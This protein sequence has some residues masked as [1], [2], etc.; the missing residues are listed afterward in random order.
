[1]RE[2]FAFPTI[3]VCRFGVIAGLPFPTSADLLLHATNA[4]ATP[5]F[6]EVIKA[7]EEKAHRV[8]INCT[9][10]CSGEGQSSGR[11]VARRSL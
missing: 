8:F 11:R 6:N 10:R 7:R 5:C 1:M 4:F 2:G 3:I 9:C